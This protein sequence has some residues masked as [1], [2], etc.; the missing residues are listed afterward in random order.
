MPVCR[1]P[2]STEQVLL[3][4]LLRHGET[5][6]GWIF[7]GQTDSPLTAEGWAQMHRALQL[8]EGRRP[9]W[10]RVISS[11]LVRCAAF[12]E[13]VAGQYA[14]PCSTHAALAEIH[15]GQWEGR[16]VQEVR[17]ETPEHVE[18][19]WRDPEQHTPPGGETIVDFQQ[20]VTHAWAQLAAA[21]NGHLLV[22]THGGV[23][24]AI[25]GELLGMPYSRL[26][27]L[28][29]PHG[30]VARVAIHRLEGFPPWPQLVSLNA[31]PES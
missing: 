16:Q 31:L 27:N 9:P 7:R 18:N 26:A 4:D 22:V 21:P 17:G 13:Q 3:I 28:C 19:F 23:I 1:G 25:L 29:I 10:Q 12:A 14:L 15:F 24:R 30:G 20:R 2:M 11:P 5:E 6:G 8:A